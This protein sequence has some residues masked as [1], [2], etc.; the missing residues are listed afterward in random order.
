MKTLAQ[1]AA[2]L[3]VSKSTIYRTIHQ[4]GFRTIQQGNKKLI[5]ESVEQAKVEVLKGKTIQNEQFKND[6]ETAQNDSER[7]GLNGAELK[8]IDVLKAQIADKD[9]QI[10]LL[11]SQITEL[12]AVK[13]KLNERLDMAETNISNL[14]T[15][16]TAAQAL[17]GMDKQ[18]AAIEVKQVND[19][20]P[21]LQR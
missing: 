13:A 17:H 6:S 5:D 19:S 11:Q 16:L 10:S 2:E 14:T 12:K 15:A 21:W 8:M 7:F 20:E 3:N 1:L 9:N 4:N 18:Q